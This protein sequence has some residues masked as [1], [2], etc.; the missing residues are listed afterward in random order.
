MSKRVIVVGGGVGGY[1]AAIRAAQLGAQVAL[2]EKDTLGGTCLNRGCIP[3][4]TLLQSANTLSL[5][6]KAQTFGISAKEVS[7]DFGAVLRRKEAV[8]NRLVSGVTFL[9]RKNK[10]R[11][12]K[13]VGTIIDSK[14]V[15]V[16]DSKEEIKGD[17]I[18]IATGSQPLMVPIKGLDEPGV[19]TSDE[20]LSLEE[21]PHSLFI[22]G[23]GAIGLEFAQIFHK[24][25][26]KVIIG[27]ILPHILPAEDV[28]IAQM[29][30][31]ILTKNGVEIFT[32]AKVISIETTVSNEKRVRFA[33]KYGEEERI[34]AKV[35]VAAGRQ[36]YTEELGVAKLGIKLDKGKIAV[37]E[38]MET[39]VAGV[40]AVG[41]VVGR[42]MLAHVA[43]SEGICAAEN[44][45]GLD[46]K[47]D[48]GAVARC[49][50][51]SPEVAS[52]GLTE[53]EA[54]RQYP[55]T[56]VA[57]FP[58]AANGRALTLDEAEGMV[59]IITSSYGEILGAIIIGPEA[60]ELIAEVTLAMHLEAT[61]ED[62]ATCIHAH[63]TL[64]EAIRETAMGIEGKAI[65]I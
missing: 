20:A 64:S 45:M 54:R 21:L 9:M 3:T 39:N 29:L 49:I 33:T 36:P 35:L 59:K 10:V 60:T 13:G 37:D 8:V 44:A 58:F 4:K 55:D 24:M 50:Y 28:E 48:Y 15:M 34:V 61:V 30:E 40:Y 14:T 7:L 47:I 1:V 16:L 38:R 22:I 52:V 43:M 19:M 32:D 6:K 41:D 25:G 63:P 26:G 12:I 51:T 42:M 27:E 2:V 17:S 31:K 18:I 46:S 5:L 23:A 62:I 56:K 57:K 65:H 53:E 11:V